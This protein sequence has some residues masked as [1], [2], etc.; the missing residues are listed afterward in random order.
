MFLSKLDAGY[1]WAT[2]PFGWNDHKMDPL[3]STGSVNCVFVPLEFEKTLDL[4]E[5]EICEK[6]G[7][8]LSLER[9]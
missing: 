7:L 4:F 8:G 6:R 1:K 3:I 9:R 5:I 2:G